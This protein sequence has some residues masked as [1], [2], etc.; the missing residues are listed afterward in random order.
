MT[1][2]FIERVKILPQKRRSTPVQETL[3]EAS[4][5]RQ[6][7]VALLEGQEEASE[8]ERWG[9]ETITQKYLWPTV[10]RFFRDH[11]IILAESGTSSFGASISAHTS[12][13]SIGR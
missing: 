4:E 3:E 12:V 1:S 9:K 6:E 8:N 11:D 10:S 5:Q 7:A 2:L 13:R